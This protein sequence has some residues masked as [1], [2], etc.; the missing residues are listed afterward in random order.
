MN[1]TVINLLFLE[2][3]ES[4]ANKD[5]F[6]NKLITKI[7]DNLQFKINSVH[8]RFEDEKN[9]QVCNYIIFYF[10][11]NIHTYIFLKINLILLCRRLHWDVL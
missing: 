6:T 11:F 7:I 8:V 1:F 5:S 3:N 2:G 4:D 10:M 9:G